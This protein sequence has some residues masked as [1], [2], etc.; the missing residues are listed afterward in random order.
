MVKNAGLGK[1]LDALF[2]NSSVL[3]E[4]NEEKAKEEKVEYIKL[5]DIEPNPSQARKK[6]SEESINELATS[7]KNY[8][9]LQPIIVENKG[10]YYQIIAGERRWRAAKVAG[11]TEIPCL[12]RNESEQTSKEIS[13]I[14]NIQRENLN[15]IEKAL[16]YKELIDNYNLKQADLADKLGISRTYVTNT[17]R[18]LNLDPRVIELALEG[19]LSEGHC[20]TLVSIEDPEQQYKLALKII[21]SGGTVKDLERTLKNK[22]KAPKKDTK[23]EAVYRD[24]EDRFEHFFGTKCQ[25]KAGSRSGSIVIKYSSNEELERILDMLN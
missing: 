20:K 15:P 2:S 4:I 21:E 9:V 10:K 3:K 7:I 18:I 22:K 19:K 25:L 12:V 14:E 17:L 16:G 6:F 13:L 11:L 5:I 1:G 8:G 24:I 23:N